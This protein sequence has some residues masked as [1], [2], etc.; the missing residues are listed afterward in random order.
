[1][2]RIWHSVTVA[3]QAEIADAV[4]SFLL[5]RGAPGLQTEERGDEVVVTGHFENPGIET[6]VEEFLDRLLEI[7]PT[8]RRPVIRSSAIEEADWAESWKD[9][10]PPLAIGARVFVHPP[11]LDAVPPGRVG[12]ELDP[13][14]AFGTGHHGS[15]QGCLTALDAL[16]SPERA[17][18][19]LDL[20][21]GSGVLAIAAV[22]LGARSALAVDIDADA[23]DIA[24]A[25]V[26][27][28]SVVEAVEITTLLDPGQTGF[29]II[30]AN[31]FS[32]MLI[33]FANDI[34]RRLNP[35]GYAIG[36]GLETAEAPAVIDAW[37]A[38]GMTRVHEYEIDGWT[39]L[40]FRGPQ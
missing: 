9:H 4:G 38:S 31:I 19:V 15:T 21:T 12:I 40:V 29:D 10:F 11:W 35:G 16:V 22:K 34:V 13:G 25:N 1:M 36:A 33:G 20:G 14:M 18:R 26:R 27:G 28:N 24:A 3:A 17:P 5:D 6:A 2:P 32:G 37:T 39:T 23:C 7:F 8:A 30:V